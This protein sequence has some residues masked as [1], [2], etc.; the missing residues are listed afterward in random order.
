MIDVADKKRASESRKPQAASPSSAR[1][2]KLYKL[3]P[4]SLQALLLPLRYEELKTYEER[5]DEL[6]EREQERDSVMK[7]QRQFD[8][9]LRPNMPVSEA[10]ALA[11]IKLLREQRG[12][13]WRLL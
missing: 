8:L 13:D 10:V 6:Q 3:L 1:I 12:D 4:P 7:L 11:R 5:C 9:P 2:V